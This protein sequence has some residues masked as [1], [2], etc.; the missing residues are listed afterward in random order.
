[1]RKLTPSERKIL[2]RLIFPEPFE[3]IQEETQLGY[4]EIR[5]DIINLMNS[6]LIEV[7]SP[8]QA[9][10]NSTHIFDSDHVKDS[11]YRITKSGINHMKN[12][13]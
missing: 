12:H 2:D 3:V 8:D 11:T 7:V 6:R 1:M 5:D 13:I 10:E 4:G 9:E